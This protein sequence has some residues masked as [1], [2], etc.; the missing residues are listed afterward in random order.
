MD[1]SHIPDFTMLEYYVAYWNYADNM[2][3][4]EALIKALV[5]KVKGGLTLYYQGQPIS[6]DGKWPRLSFR[7][8]ILKDTGINLDEHPNKDSLLAAI[9]SAGISLDLEPRLENVG[10]GTLIDLLYK[11]V[12]RPNI[13]Y[14]IFLVQHPVDVSPLARSNDDN[15]AVVDRFQLVVNGWEVVNT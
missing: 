7:D 11:K 4:T 3:F 13:E 9:D 6:F 14:P 1:R 2:A 8:L 10:Y 15:P 12:S 5:E